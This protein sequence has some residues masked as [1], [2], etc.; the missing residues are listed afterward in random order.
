M[1]KPKNSDQP[2][3][4]L[5]GLEGLGERTT[6]AELVRS[7]G[8]SKQLQVITQK[9]LMD[10]ILSL[11][12]TQMA[13]RADT[14]SDKEKDELLKK[15][16]EQLDMRI[17]REKDAQADRDR[18]KVD[19]DR[20]MAKI[21]DAQS[22]STSTEQMA[23]AIQALKI[24]LQETEQVNQD[25]QQDTYDLHDQLN[26]KLALVSATIAEKDKLKETVKNQIRRSNALVESV[27]GLDASLY[28]SRHAEE[29]PV[30]DDAD[31][32]SEFY[33]DFEVGTKVI[34]TL[35]SDLER[36]RSIAKKSSQ[37]DKDTSNDSRANLLES[38]LQLLEQLKEGNLNAVDVAEP[39]EGLVEAT[40]GA[41]TEAQQL[42]H[43]GKQALGVAAG[44]EDAISA[45]PNTESGAPAEV[46]AGTTGVVRELAAVMARG[47]QRLIVLKE[48]SDQADE[49][50]NSA[51]LELE[52]VRGAYQ[53]VL[54][55]LA[56]RAAAEKIHLPMALKYADAPSEESRDKAI[57][58]ISQLRGSG[59]DEVAPIIKE[60]I[61]RIDDL[62]G[63]EVGVTM[64]PPAANAD[65]NALVA[66][67]REDS[68]ALAHLLQEKT[69]ELAAAKSREKAIA[70]EVQALAKIENITPEHTSDQQLDASIVTLTKALAD[71]SNTKQIGN[72]AHFV[73][74]K[75]REQ[76]AK[77]PSSA[78]VKRLDDERNRLASQIGQ[79]QQ[80][81]QQLENA[82]TQA[83]ADAAT[84]LTAG[85]D[86]SRAERGMAKALVAAAQGDEQLAEAVA[87]LALLTDSEEDENLAPALNEAVT[88]LARRK[89]DLSEE[90]Q[91]LAKELSELK[92]KTQ[93][94]EK[95]HLSFQSDQDK[96]SAQLAQAQQQ[97]QD[98]ERDLS[99]SKTDLDL[100]RNQAQE[101]NSKRTA[102]DADRSKAVAQAES[103]E[104]RLRAA[105]KDLR[106]ANNELAAAKTN[107]QARY[108]AERAIATEL[109]RAAQG[110]AELA[111]ATADL[112]LS[113]EDTDSSNAPVDNTLVTR[114]AAN[115]ISIL[116]KRKLDLEQ[117]SHLLQQ[118]I[119]SLKWKLKESNEDGARV[120]AEAED[121]MTGVKDIIST[122]TMKR[123]RTV[124]ELDELKKIAAE[125][126]NKL[127]RSLHRTSA[128]ETANRQLAE[129]LSH[130][131]AIETEQDSGDVEDKRV[132]LELALSQLP[133]EGEDAVTIPED[134]S[135]Q[136]ASS[137]QKL[138]QAL[139]SRR[140]QMTSSFKR[141]KADQDSL[142]ED[143]QK[144]RDEL[145]AAQKAN[146][147]QQSALRSSQA[148]VKAVRQELTSQGKDLAAKVQELT[149]LR[150]DFA[151]IK[152]ELDVSEQRI[153]ENDRRLQQT[154]AK[155]QESLKEHERLVRDLGEQQQRADASEHAQ[156]HMV[157]LLRSL[158]NRQDTQSVVARALTDADMA[159]P[160]SKAAQKL[161][162][163]RS[164]GPEH[165][166]NASQ[167]YVQ[168]LKDRV[169]GLAED[170]E[171]KRGQLTTTKTHT[172]N[173]QDE[174]AALRASVFDRDHNQQ[175][176]EKELD[177]AKGEQTTILSQLMEQRRARDEVAAQLK[178]AHEELRLAQADVADFQARDGASSGYLSGDIERLRDELNKE[179]SQREALDAELSDLRDQSESGDARL[180]AQRDEFMRHLAERDRTIEQ[181]ERQL[182]DL[183][184]QRADTKGLQAQVEALTGELAQANDRIKEYE[185]VYGASAGANAKTTDL[186]RELKK[187]NAERDQL[188]EK[189]RQV[190]VDHADSVSMN[191]QLQSQLADKRKDVGNS[192]EKLAKDMNDLRDAATTVREENRRLKEE[193]VGM[194]ARIRRLTDNSSG[195]SGG[196]PIN[197]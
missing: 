57:T 66:R 163:A 143:V 128:A 72:A 10:W 110:D 115:S 188:R 9:T 35:S 8:Q 74:V 38:D 97:V 22:N 134:L 34:E 116:A 182:N 121:M 140:Q 87:D 7:K 90:N 113:L 157:Q 153:E 86:R 101:A 18:L 131:A 17:K 142:K 16:K 70:E 26:D 158:T 178:S 58:I 51:E 111:E 73:I 169:Q 154:N 103:L 32:E 123:D 84:A 125:D 166:A 107:M 196:F 136:L 180:K 139:L 48:M 132:D 189:L 124:A 12:N 191:A 39:V 28:G 95:R 83:K 175:N 77:A 62:L 141:A 55:K 76:L 104:Q 68:D 75:L 6:A 69:A 172:S 179:R 112:A 40:N 177:K 176:L 11:I 43:T 61:R 162:M 54:G 71:T 120:T 152:A 122:L 137:G 46:L 159:D 82:L 2:I 50:R 170:L 150:G 156:T 80:K 59:G 36:L 185:G 168:A 190:E 184:E 53:Q 92:A 63:K 155:L 160:L 81:I 100:M 52:E 15:T 98:L 145:A 44:R 181:K 41:R 99:R 105:E 13:G 165:L 88:G 31:D 102:I 151:S 96:Q 30:L 89:H 173:L 19:L 78:D 4:N 49:A 126:Q 197:K 108:D 187:L 194:K 174:L 114:Q 24:K 106:Q 171:D 79:A 47:R 33:H 117:N 3:P 164:A 138:A 25:L 195:P 192:R 1:V 91:R 94:A 135:L 37:K 56:E 167:S 129:A 29:N 60:Q 65:T 20:A 64:A 148:E 93:D 119:D 42:E 45:V 127:A 149:N 109:V 183:T 147:N 67:L 5:S 14:F 161:D 144:V 27:M 146:E 130:L 21:A 118:E 193:L 23:E 133:D 85:K 186:A